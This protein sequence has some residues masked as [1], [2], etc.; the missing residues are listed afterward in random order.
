[1]IFEKHALEIEQYTAFVPFPYLNVR[2]YIFFFLPF[3]LFLPLLFRSFFFFPFYLFIT[4]Y[5]ER[6][7]PLTFK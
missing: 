7:R 5:R 2:E 3:N 4:R 1:M 6:V